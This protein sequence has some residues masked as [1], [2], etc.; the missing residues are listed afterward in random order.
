MEI[1]ECLFSQIV[2]IRQMKA[3][4]KKLDKSDAEWYRRN[5]KIV[6]LKVKYTAQETDLLALWGGGQC[7]KTGI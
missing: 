3:E 4:G 6:D 5:R 7:A 1:G 2:H